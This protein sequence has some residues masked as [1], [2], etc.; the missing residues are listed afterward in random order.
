MLKKADLKLEFSVLPILEISNLAIHSFAQA[1]LV[2]IRSV[3]R[4]HKWI[5]Y[6]FFQF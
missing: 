1:Q 4:T 6:T 2:K 3:Q 5:N